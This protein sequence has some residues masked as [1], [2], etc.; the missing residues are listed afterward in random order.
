[1]GSILRKNNSNFSIHNYNLNIAGLNDVLATI[2]SRW[3]LRV[4]SEIS[5]GKNQFMH[6][7]AAFPTATNH[8]LTKRI[9]ELENEKFIVR[10]VANSDGLLT[11]SYALTTKSKDLLEVIEQLQ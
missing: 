11:V 3:K 7:K 5:A 10:V 4:L 9:T 1:M 2:N 6:L 8:S